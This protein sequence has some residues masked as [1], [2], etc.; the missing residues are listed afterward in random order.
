MTVPKL[1]TK[2]LKQPTIYYNVGFFCKN[3]FE[4]RQQIEFQRRL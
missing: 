4:M 1:R 3:V 2:M